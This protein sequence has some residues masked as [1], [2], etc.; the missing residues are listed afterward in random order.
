MQEV[1]AFSSLVS[2]FSSLV[3]CMERD[4]LCSREIG[5]HLD[6]S[7]MSP[8]PLLGK[9]YISCLDRDERLTRVHGKHFDFGKMD[10]E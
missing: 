3:G 10:L 4:T 7:E 8:N 1:S 9:G 5:H 6:G 2:A